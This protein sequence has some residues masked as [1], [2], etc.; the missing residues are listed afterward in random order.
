MKQITHRTFLNLGCVVSYFWHAL[1]CADAKGIKFGKA[2]QFGENFNFSGFF[3]PPPLLSLSPVFKSRDLH[4]FNIFCHG[5]QSH[6]SK[7][8]IHPSAEINNC[9]RFRVVVV[10]C[11]AKQ[12]DHRV[13][14]LLPSPYR[15]AAFFFNIQM[16]KY[17]QCL[18]PSSWACCEWRRS[19]TFNCSTSSQLLS[20]VCS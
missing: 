4:F 20:F 9:R 8:S 6:D 10:G 2:Q 14:I 1:A 17:H 7:I 3:F 5:A 12:T 19:L 15:T 11:C 13:T 16:F 18:H